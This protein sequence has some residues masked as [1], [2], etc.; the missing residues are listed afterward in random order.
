[1]GLQALFQRTEGISVVGESCSAR[2]A[3]AEA[4]RLQPD[5]VLMDLRLPDGCGVEACREILAHCPDTRV[6]F[7]TSFPDEDAVLSTTFARASG[8]LLKTIGGRALIE[9]IKAVA[10][11]GSILDPAVTEPVLTRMRS[12]SARAAENS[13]EQ[14]LSPQE[15]RLLP[16]IAEGKTNKEIAVALGLAE[17]TIKSYLRNVFQK[18]Q[19]SRRTQI[20][21]R[22][23]K[24]ASTTSI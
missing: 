2:D 7:L 8:Y 10:D 23:A 24:A 4:E 20:A 12:L 11:G 19:V 6:L 15:R 21:A 5:L 9:A 3:V 16:L 13:E 1:M 14:A 17:K 22:F 18:L